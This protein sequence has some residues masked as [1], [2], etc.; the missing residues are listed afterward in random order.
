[1]RPIV[2][3]DNYD[4]FTFNL[5]QQIA[6]LLTP[7]ERAALTVIRN[8]QCSADEVCGLHPRAVVISPGPGRPSDAGISVP[9]VRCLSGAAPILGVCLGHQ[10]IG[11]V[12]G[13]TVQRAPRPIHGRTSAIRHHGR[14][15]FYGIPS[16]VRFVRYHSLALSSDLAGTPLMVDAWS[17]DQVVMAI[18]HHSEPTY[19]VQFHPESFLSPYGSQL[20]ANFLAESARFHT[21]PSE[22]LWI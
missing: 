16:P 5:Y 20:I 9:L 18:S 21:Q 14:G 13:L 7:E 19:G 15:L 4:S 2:I 1:M 3:I 12:F 17:E 11:E 22:G 8:D 6:L 10:V